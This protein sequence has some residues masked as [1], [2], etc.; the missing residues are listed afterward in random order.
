LSFMR[1]NML[2]TLYGTIVMMVMPIGAVSSAQITIDVGP[3]SIVPNGVRKAPAQKNQSQQGA[4]GSAVRRMGVQVTANGKPTVADEV[5]ADGNRDAGALDAQP[6]SKARIERMHVQPQQMRSLVEAAPSVVA[7]SSTEDILGCWGTTNNTRLLHGGPLDLQETKTMLES[8]AQAILVSGQMFPMSHEDALALKIPRCPHY[9]YDST[10]L[11]DT[12]NSQALFDENVATDTNAYLDAQLKGMDKTKPVI[13]GVIEGFD[14]DTRTSMSELSL[15][16]ICGLRR[17]G[18]DSRLVIYAVDNVTSVKLASLVGQGRVLHHPGIKAAVSLASNQTQVWLDNRIAK[19]VL[20]LMLLERGYS[21]ILSDIDTYWVR[22]PTPYLLSLGVDFAA[23]SDVCCNTLNSGFVYYS[24]SPKSRLVLN[25]ALMTK[26]WQNGTHHLNADN[27]QY[28]LNC[29]HGQAFA[30]EG[31]R[32]TL[33]PRPGFAFGAMDGFVNFHC[34]GKAGVPTTDKS[35][36][37]LL[38]YLWHTAGT[39]GEEAEDTT[40]MLKTVGFWDLRRD[41]NVSA[42]L[43]AGQGYCLDG[44]RGTSEQS[45]EDARLIGAASCRKAWHPRC[46]CQENSEHF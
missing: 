43:S 23:Q 45:Q 38:P 14:P 3:S 32:S 5:V 20:P 22:D 44:A 12:Q 16:F 6:L 18:L 24:A 36:E 19:L 25:L 2:R 28:L 26:K 10:A 31:L 34:D 9:D 8:S 7:D 30:Y 11:I 13:V 15:N 33:L 41:L 40:R 29:A 37:L 39:S 35:G 17:L 4:W 42:G 21:V 1:R 46:R 27:D